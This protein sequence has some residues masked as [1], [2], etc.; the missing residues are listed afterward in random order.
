MKRIAAQA[1]TLHQSDLASTDDLAIGSNRLKLNTTVAAVGSDGQSQRPSSPVAWAAMGLARS[2]R[3]SP[4]ATRAGLCAAK[5]KLAASLVA[6]LKSGNI[7]RQ[8]RM[9]D[10]ES[11]SSKNVAEAVRKS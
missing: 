11:A 6:K 4:S 8:M 10:S 3:A 9:K 1:H 2:P 7:N 5:P